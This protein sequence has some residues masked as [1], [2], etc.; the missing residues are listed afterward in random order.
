MYQ[1]QIFKSQPLPDGK[2]LVYTLY[3]TRNPRTDEASYQVEIQLYGP[4]GTYDNRTGP[5]NLLAFFPLSLWPHLRHAV[6]Q[7]AGMLT[8]RGLLPPQPEWQGKGGFITQEDLVFTP[9]IGVDFVKI[10][11]ERRQE[12]AGN[13]R[14]RHRS[15][16]YLIWP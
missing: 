15:E 1:K 8:D 10:I 12:N 3:T 11:L 5:L 7:T 14:S 13:V 9:K 16:H 2:W 6:A 4:W